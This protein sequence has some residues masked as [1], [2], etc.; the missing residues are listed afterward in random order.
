MIVSATEFKMNLGKYLD[1]VNQ[2]EITI[3]RNGKTVAKLV[4]EE[5]DL[6]ALT[7]SLFGI[8]PDSGKSYDEMKLE[9]MK[10]RYGDY[11]NT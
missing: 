10:E 6:V 8:V 2:E 11:L 3:T 7:E 9:A 1:L 5:E 4:P